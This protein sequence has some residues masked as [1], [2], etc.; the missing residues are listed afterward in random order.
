MVLKAT[1]TANEIGLKVKTMLEDNYSGLL[2][3]L[4]KQINKSEKKVIY[5][6]KRLQ[7]IVEEVKNNG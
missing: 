4:G 3:N 7:E 6:Y 2:S 1:R 5:S